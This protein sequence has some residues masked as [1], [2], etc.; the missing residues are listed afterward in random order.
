MFHP[1]GERDSCRLAN[2]DVFFEGRRLEHAC[3]EVGEADRRWGLPCAGIVRRRLI[4][5]SAAETLAV[6]ETVR[7]MGF[8]PLAGPR[9]GQFAVDALPPMRLIFRPAHDPVPCL[10]DG[11]I[12]LA[13]VTAIRILAIAAH[14]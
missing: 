6:L 7:P 3:S 10:P 8:R 11:D 5:L 14:H 1:S 9:D 4:Q 12:D 2:V 13:Q